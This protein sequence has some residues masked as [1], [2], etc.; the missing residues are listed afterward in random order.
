MLWEA[1]GGW[2]QGAVCDGEKAHEMGGAHSRVQRTGG[3]AVGIGVLGVAGVGRRVQRPA[4]LLRSVVAR[5]SGVL[6]VPRVGGVMHESSRVVHG[7]VVVAGAVAS[8]VMADFDGDSTAGR[9]RVVGGIGT[10]NH[11]GRQVLGL[12]CTHAAGFDQN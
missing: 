4:L 9:Q 11:D 6:R 7:G 3:D 1:G 12:F 8:R 2:R 10:R 5:A